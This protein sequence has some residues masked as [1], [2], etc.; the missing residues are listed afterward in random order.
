MIF[1]E[2]SLGFEYSTCDYLVFFGKK[3]ASIDNL[4]AMYPYLNF[5]RLRQCHSDISVKISHEYKDLSQEGDALFT[6]EKNIALA[7]ST[8]D[9]IPVLIINAEKTEISAVHSGWRG[10]EKEITSKTISKM[11]GSE[12]TIYI[13]PHILMSSFEVSEETKNVLIN[14]IDAKSRNNLL[15]KIDSTHYLL[16]LSLILKNHLLSIPNIFYTFETL[17]LDTKTDFRFHSY[18][19]DKENSGRQLSFIALR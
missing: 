10:V 5:A 14:N 1:T 6:T 2:N 17:L 18:R 16:D 7:I 15:R 9:C 8:A 11:G 3:E 12:F 13:G 4:K 19:R